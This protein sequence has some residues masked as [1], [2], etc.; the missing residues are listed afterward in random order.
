MTGQVLGAVMTNTIV[1]FAGELPD[2]LEGVEVCTDG[3]TSDLQAKDYSGVLISVTATWLTMASATV[4]IITLSRL[5]NTQVSYLVQEP[6]I[7]KACSR[8]NPALRSEKL[9]TWRR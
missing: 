9:D 6:F 3:L 5:R 7:P 1:Y 4:Y 2:A 8:S